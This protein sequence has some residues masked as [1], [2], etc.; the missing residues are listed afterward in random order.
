[1]MIKLRYT[2]WMHI[3]CMAFLKEGK[4]IRSLIETISILILRANGA[5][6][7]TVAKKWTACCARFLSQYPFI[8]VHA[9][10]TSAVTPCYIIAEAVMEIAFCHNNRRHEGQFTGHACDDQRSFPA[11]LRRWRMLS[12]NVLDAR[13]KW[14]RKRMSAKEKESEKEWMGGWKEGVTC[15]RDVI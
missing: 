7:S 14:A 11:A 13:A 9:D 6:S 10:I 1:M 3:R 2:S 15:T 4:N 8:S 12:A 5:A